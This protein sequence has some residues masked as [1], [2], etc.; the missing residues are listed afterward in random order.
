MLRLK[1]LLLLIII[2]GSSSFVMAGTTGKIAGKVIDQTTGE[3]LIGANVFIPELN[4][5]GS[6]DSEGYYYIINVPPGEYDVK[7]S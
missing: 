6:T 7:A 4:I 3:P 1:L 5:G 2:L